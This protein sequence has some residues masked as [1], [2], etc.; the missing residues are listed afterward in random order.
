MSKLPEVM[1]KYELPTKPSYHITCSLNVSQ[2]FREVWD[3]N[4]NHV[5][6]TYLLLLNGA[7]LIIGYYKLSVGGTSSTIVDLKLIFQTLLLTNANSF[8]LAHNHPSGSLIPSVQDKRLTG[9]I[10][11]ASKIMDIQFLDHMIITSDSYFSFA[12]EGILV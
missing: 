6:S 8:I 7:N 2:Y 12:D 10:L 1:L 11:K 9:K 3:D 5:E 4:L